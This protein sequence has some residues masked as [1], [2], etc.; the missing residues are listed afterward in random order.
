MLVSADRRNKRT[1]TIAEWTG[2]IAEWTD[3]IAE[4]TD[5]IAEWT[6]TIAEWTGTIAE[7][8]GKSFARNPG[9]CPQASEVESA[10]ATF[11]SPCSAPTTLAGYGTSEP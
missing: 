6:G 3:T 8:T 4:W 7:W 5:T 11:V 10:G 1:D 9:S 2:T